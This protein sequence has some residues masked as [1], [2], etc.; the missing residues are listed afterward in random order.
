MFL[1]FLTKTIQTMNKPISIRNLF[2]L[3]IRVFL[4]SFLLMVVVTSV[5]SA[6]VTT[7]TRP[8]GVISDADL[9]IPV[10]GT[11]TDAAG[12]PLPG[13]N[14]VEKGTTNG[15][16]T[17]VSGRFSLNV[18]GE[19]SVLVFSFIGYATQEVAVGNRTDFSINLLEDVQALQEVVVVGYGTQE[20]VN[21]TGAV[22]VTTGEALKNRP[23]ANVG[24]GL[25]GVVP[26]L[27]VNIRNGDPSE[28]IDFNIRGYESINGGAP[29]V[30][31]DGVPM[32]LNTL[33]PSDIE[34]V[35][36]LKDA[37]AAAVYGAR[38]AFGV[39]LVTTK[40]GKGEKY[41]WQNPSF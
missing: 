2:T 6:R 1:A 11:V 14:V 22:G 3:L 41:R 9:A 31:V 38:A 33:N 37:S 10:S 19:T 27:N 15:T 5:F 29:L 7:S 40:K 8:G 36:V 20:K 4:T 18:Q 23:I 25:Q 21:L 28:P 17:D 12:V 13:V 39:I 16:T 35:S 26:N 24:E 32:D 30:L 34:S